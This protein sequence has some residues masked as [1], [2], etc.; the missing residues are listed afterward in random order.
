M[1]SNILPILKSPRTKL[2]VLI[3]PDNQTE[4]SLTELA[5]KITNC[6]VDMILVGG[7]LLLAAF[8]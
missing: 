8:L 4:K 7:S 1:K 5:E 2:A 3:D 6:K